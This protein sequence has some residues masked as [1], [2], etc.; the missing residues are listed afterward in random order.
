[1]YILVLYEN[2]FIVSGSLLWVSLSTYIAKSTIKTN[3]IYIVMLSYWHV[4]DVVSM[5]INDA[6]HISKRLLETPPVSLWIFTQ[7][8]DTTEV[9]SL[10]FFLHSAL[11]Q[12][13]HRST[14]KEKKKKATLSYRMSPL[15][16]MYPLLKNE[17]QQ[18]A[19][20]DKPEER[21]KNLHVY[22]IGLPF[23]QD[24]DCNSLSK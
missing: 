1:M 14:E 22:D 7:H 12:R 16:N 5:T 17:K 13:G 20:T 3:I 6:V 24:T 21:I 19:Q 11:Y 4:N 10:L 9:E 2:T 8:C 23:S 18:V 15:L